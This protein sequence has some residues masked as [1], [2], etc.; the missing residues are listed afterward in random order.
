MKKNKSEI[1]IVLDKS[2]SMYSC[3][4]DMQGALNAF[5]KDQQKDVEDNNSECSVTFVEF[6][7]KYSVVFENKDIKTIPTLKLNPRGSTALLDALGY[8]I[9]KVGERLNATA[10]SEKPS[11]VVFVIITDG[12]ENSSKEFKREVVLDKIKEQKEKYSWE[13]I[14]LGANQDAIQEGSNYGFSAGKSM[15]Y[16]QEPEKIRAMANTLSDSVSSLRKGFDYN[17]SDEERNKAE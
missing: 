14:Y 7:N 3:Q 10:E 6:D 13:F 16:S 9:N 4:S 12:M 5:V 8:T 17:F 2:G 15:T 1:V 11:S